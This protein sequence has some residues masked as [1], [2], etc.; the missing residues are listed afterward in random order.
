M[1]L[2]LT[3]FA[4]EVVREANLD[5]FEL[6]SNLKFFAPTS[7]QPLELHASSSQIVICELKSHKVLKK[8]FTTNL[9]NISVMDFGFTLL[10]KC[11]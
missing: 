2:H 4:L 1:P 11:V 10:N 6:V 5:F 3:V 8:M 7:K 9:L